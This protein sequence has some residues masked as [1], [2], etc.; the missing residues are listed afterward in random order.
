MLHRTACPMV[1]S[2]AMQRGSFRL[3]ARM[4]R[5]KSLSFSVSATGTVPP[6]ASSASLQ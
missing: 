1:P 6:G 3:V 5:R 4:T 2:K